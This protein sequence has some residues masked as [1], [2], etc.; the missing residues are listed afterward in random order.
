MVVSRAVLFP[1]SSPP[2]LLCFRDALTTCFSFEAARAPTML[3]ATTCAVGDS[4]CDAGAP[5]GSRPSSAT[6][7]LVE[8]DEAH[9][10]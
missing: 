2:A 8:P 4:L 10:H 5:F 3:A 9:V 1:P 6:G 7:V